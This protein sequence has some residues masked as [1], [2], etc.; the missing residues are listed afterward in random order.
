MRLFFYVRLLSLRACDLKYIVRKKASKCMIIVVFLFYFFYFTILFHLPCYLT[1]HF[2]EW[3]RL[4]RVAAVA[5]HLQPT[6]HSA[7][8]N[9]K[10][11]PEFYMLDALMCILHIL[12]ILTSTCS[13]SNCMFSDPFTLALDLSSF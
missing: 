6:M 11:K 1:Y 2:P 3:P 9:S 13:E 8:L 12:Y 4:L 10:T 5:Q 7:S